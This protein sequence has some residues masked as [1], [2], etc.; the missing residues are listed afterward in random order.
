MIQ[1]REF[2]LS[3]GGN[4]VIGDQE[5]Q[6]I[7]LTRINRTEIVSLLVVGLDAL[8]KAFEK[9]NGLPLWNDK[10]FKSRE[11]LSGSAFH[12]FNTQKIND[13]EFA[14]VKS[15]VGDI[16]TQ[17][18]GNMAQQIVEFLTSNGGKKFGS[19]T[20]IGFKNSASQ[21]ISLWKLEKYDL[22]VQVDLELVEFGPDGK[23]SPW[24]QFS[25]SSAWND[26][27]VGIKGVAHKYLMQA[28]NSRNVHELVIKS[29]SA[30][31]KDKQ[32]QSSVMA[33]SV[34]HGL[35]KRLDAVTDESGKHVHENGLPTYKELSTAESKGNTNL[36]EI[37]RFYFGHEPSAADL[38]AMGSFLGL[39]GLIAKHITDKKERD[40]VIDGFINKLWGKG[41]Q[42]LYRGDKLRDFR[43]K[44]VMAK[45]LLQTFNKDFRAYRAMIRDYYRAYK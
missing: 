13:G 20:L 11:F 3:E 36:G 45:H 44:K 15:T 39:E 27:T 43:E 42:G 41:A 37:Y 40:T 2:L 34:T 10:L 25:H 28:L 17:V 23:P 29:K 33:F 12:F 4:V 14:R 38:T 19:M 35:R 6:R 24:A 22:N 5:A 31:G 21:L 26:L 8:N 30:R 9:K 1:F 32:T 7:D 18:D 16:D